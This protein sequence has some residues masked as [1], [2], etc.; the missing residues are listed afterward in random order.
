MKIVYIHCGLGNQMFQYAFYKFL[1]KQGYKHLRLEATA[2]SMRRHGGFLLKKIFPAIAANKDFL[3]YWPARIFY[4]LVGD[5][6]KKGFKFNLM[7]DQYPIPP[8]TLWLKGYWQDNQF[9]EDVIAEL[10][11]DFDFL[12]VTDEKNKAALEQIRTSNAVSVHIRRGD[13]GDPNNP[14]TAA[15]VCS[16]PY[17]EKAIAYIRS[18][19]EN[20][21]FFI[22]SD[23]PQ[24]VRDNLP[25]DNAVYV[26]WNKQQTSFRDMQLMS[27]CKHNIIANSSFS[28]WGARLNRN[29][30]KVVVCPSVWFYNYPADFI[31]KLIPA[32]WHKLT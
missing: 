27:E 2:P 1:K 30:S 7:T 16:V 29:P 14:T 13:Y 18:K 5:V 9:V 32:G 28:W 12:P 25:V 26:D 3:P 20:P 31:E 6:L 8:R 17:Y 21:R 19:V 22:F 24:W 23:D 10:Y 11:T 4:L 15:S